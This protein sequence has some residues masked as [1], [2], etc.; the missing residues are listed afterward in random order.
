[1]IPNNGRDIKDTTDGCLSNRFNA[2]V[3]PYAADHKECA[4]DLWD[5]YSW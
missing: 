3:I 2:T 5:K 1:M 4:Q